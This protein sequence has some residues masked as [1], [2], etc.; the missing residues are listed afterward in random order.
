M[1]LLSE[2][3][4]SGFLKLIV[5]TSRPKSETRYI[6]HAF[7]KYGI[8]P[9]YILTDLFHSKRILVNDF[10][11]TNPFPTAIA[12]NLE[13]DSDQLSSIFKSLSG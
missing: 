10:S 5:T 12:V 8:K 9:D 4:K 7:K 1:E 6:E 13:R 2:I 11:E 3:N